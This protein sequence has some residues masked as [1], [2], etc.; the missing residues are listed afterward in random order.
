MKP[1]T[2]ACKISKCKLLQSAVSSPQACSKRFTLYSLADLFTQTP[3]RV[4][5]ETFSH[6]APNSRRLP[7]HTYSPLSI[8]RYSFIQL[9]ELEQLILVESPILY[10]WATALLQACVKDDL[11]LHRLDIQLNTSP[12]LLVRETAL[13]S[14]IN[15]LVD[16]TTSA[17]TAAPTRAE[18]THTGT[19]NHP[20]ALK[21]TNTP[22]F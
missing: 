8:A 18:A 12:D 10:P 3:S 9:S 22:S 13:V 17:L 19:Y 11:K 1:C 4:L 2:D 15:N 5:H 6:A 7:V 21:S 14:S 16:V 20:P